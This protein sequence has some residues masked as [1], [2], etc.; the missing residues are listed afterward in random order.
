MLKVKI[1][2]INDKH[3]FEF[4]IQEQKIHYLGMI[5]AESKR[6]V[7]MELL[8]EFAQSLPID[9]E[10]SNINTKFVAVFMNQSLDE[11]EFALNAFPFDMIQLH[12]EETVGYC[13]KIKKMYP[14][15]QTIK[16]LSIPHNIIDES[17]IIQDLQ[18]KISYYRNCVDMFLLDT[19]IG[20]LVGGTGEVFP[21][22]VVKPLIDNT[23][24]DYPIGIA[25][26]L[27]PDNVRNLMETIAPDFIDVNSGLEVDGIKNKDKI[28]QL[29]NVLE[30]VN[31]VK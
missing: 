26:G 16:T 31:R 11:V 7:T 28:L 1:C 6:K 19:K 4:L 20:N 21:W 13:K 18:R 14:N 12:G 8:S 25:G 29:M 23:Y 30:G 22:D 5:F 27:H 2:G 24:R 10:N 9:K 17:L 3:I 15:I